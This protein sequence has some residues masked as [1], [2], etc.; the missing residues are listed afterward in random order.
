[1]ADTLTDYR[2]ITDTRKH[3]TNWTEL[4]PVEKKVG[5]R[6]NKDV[7]A[8]TL[9]DIFYSFMR[10]SRKRQAQYELSSLHDLVT[11]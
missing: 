10:F 1:M 3:R 4:C 7:V 6:L 9:I 5:L 11:F 8:N 2:L